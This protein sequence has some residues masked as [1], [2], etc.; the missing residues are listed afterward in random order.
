MCVVIDI[1]SA[2]MQSDKDSSNFAD[3]NNRMDFFQVPMSPLPSSEMPG[4]GWFSSSSRRSPPAIVLNQAS[5]LR[6]LNRIVSDLN[7]IYR[8]MLQEVHGAVK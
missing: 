5:L 4:T 7:H 3:P 1:P 6:N 8:S 2:D